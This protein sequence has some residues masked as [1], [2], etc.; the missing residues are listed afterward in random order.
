MIY[1]V[2]EILQFL[3]HG[4]KWKLRL[5]PAKYWA[6]V[7]N[8]ITHHKKQQQQH[9]RKNIKSRRNRSVWLS[10]TARS[11]NGEDAASHTHDE[12]PSQS[13]FPFFDKMEIGF[14]SLLRLHRRSVW[15]NSC[16]RARIIDKVW[17]A[18]NST[19]VPSEKGNTTSGEFRRRMG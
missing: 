14:V 7:K 17:L 1:L 8:D 10:T 13:H 9:M 4:N 15:T 18:A 19:T 16:P 11:H 12:S 5:I 3:L 2:S 6:W